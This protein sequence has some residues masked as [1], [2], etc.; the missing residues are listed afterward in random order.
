MTGFC[1]I[2]QDA[3]VKKNMFDV[4]AAI[5]MPAPF[6]QL[7]HEITHGDMPAVKVLMQ[8][9]QAALIWLWQHYWSKIGHNHANLALGH[10]QSIVVGASAVK[11]RIEPIL[12]GFLRV[13]RKEIQCSLSSDIE[14]NQAARTAC[15]ELVRLCR[16]RRQ[17]L[18]ILADCLVKEK[19][20]L[21]AFRG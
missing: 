3:K 8:H 19:V 7:R 18:R 11:E 21:P 6:V 1:D 14:P 9:T 15:T 13:R 12:H 5:Q 4:A 10:D 2:G 16:G 20:M 17:N